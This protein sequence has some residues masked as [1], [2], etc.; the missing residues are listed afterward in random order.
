MR[1]SMRKCDIL[2][3]E[4]GTKNRDS[5]ILMPVLVYLKTEEKYQI[6][7]S[8][9][10]YGVLKLIQ[11]H[12]KMLLVANPAGAPELSRVIKLAYFLGIKTVSLISEGDVVD[13]P[14]RAEGF[15]WGWNFEKQCYL[16]LFLLWSER[17]RKIFERYILESKEFNIK[18]SGATGFDRY[19]L[20]KSTYMTKE[21]FCVKHRKTYDKIIGITSWGFSICFANQTNDEKNRF[22]KK[23]CMKLREVL[24]DI[25]SH[26]EDILFVL[27][28]HPGEI[29]S[30]NE[31]VGLQDFENVI[32]IQAKDEPV[33]DN[34]NAC[35]M[36]MAFDSTTCMEAWLL[37]KPT[38]LINPYPIE[39]SRSI[40]HKGS[41][42]MRDAHD[43]ISCIEEFYQNGKIE[44]F[45]CL[46]GERKKIIQDVIGYSDGKNF[47]RAGKEIITIMNRDI[48]RKTR[49][50]IEFLRELLKDCIKWV[51]H[52]SFLIKIRDFEQAASYYK[53]FVPKEC[54]E[55]EEMYYNAIYGKGDVL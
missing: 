7:I 17:S 5:N 4:W 16:D 43:T 51:W 33:S 23:S 26:F 8:S 6:E 20:L 38:L 40:I 42:I 34:I 15:F 13:D 21:Q 53:D 36:W 45:E 18:V 11:Y 29:G 54:E 50:T 14:K 41:P 35:D 44:A 28:L 19:K 12:P 3:L 55:E 37:E 39:F 30:E 10:A 46:D 9:L 25:V 24:Y 2:C 52:H 1:R 27:R 49:I 32:I 22:Y 31:F 48:N 47:V